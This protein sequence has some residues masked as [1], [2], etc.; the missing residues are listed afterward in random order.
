MNSGL[1]ERIE[2]TLEPTLADECLHVVQLDPGLAKQASVRAPREGIDGL[3]EESDEAAT[4]RVDP[5]AD[6][7]VAVGDGE[8]P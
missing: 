8:R 5:L 1:V 6:Q 3:L 7:S 2:R 4:A